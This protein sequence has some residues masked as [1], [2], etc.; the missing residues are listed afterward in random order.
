MKPGTS[1]V[2]SGL[3]N[4]KNPSF[5]IPD[6]TPQAE[7]TK[8]GAKPDKNIYCPMSGK[9]L[10][11]KDLIDVKFKEIKP[12]D[13]ESK[14]SI[15]ARDERY[16]CA[17]TSDVLNNSTP[18]AVLKPS[19]DVITVECVEKIVKKDMLHPLTGQMLKEGDIIYLQ[20]GGTGYS[21]TNEDSLRAEKYRPN[22]ALS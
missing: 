12:K 8:M 22:M 15:I 19:G 10:K 1:G 4:N 16:M 7:K 13:G 9:P 3:K 18:V 11:M 2:G 17:V 6:V 21:A 20:R 14:K 5:W